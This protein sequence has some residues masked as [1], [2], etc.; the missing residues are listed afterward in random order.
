M[1]LGHTGARHHEVDIT[2]ERV[3]LLGESGRRFRRKGG[4][5]RPLG[6]RGF[7]A[8]PD[9]GCPSAVHPGIF[10][11]DDLVAPGPAVSY[12]RVAGDPESDHEHSHPGR[13]PHQSITPGRRMKSA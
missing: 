6:E 2:N 9:L 10:Q 7:D 11:D 13:A 8:S 5:P 12:D 3:D 4:Q 1:T